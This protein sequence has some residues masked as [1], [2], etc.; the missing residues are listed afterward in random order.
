MSIKAS[1]SAFQLEQ[2]Y[3]VITMEHEEVHDIEDNEVCKT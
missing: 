2:D 1:A 3:D